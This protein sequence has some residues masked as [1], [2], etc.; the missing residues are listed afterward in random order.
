MPEIIDSP[1]KEI[2][3]DLLALRSAVASEGLQF[4]RGRC[5]AIAKLIE[6]RLHLPR[7]SGLFVDDDGRG[8]PHEWNVHPQTREIADLS[9]SQ[10]GSQWRELEIFPPRDIEETRHLAG[11]TFT[12]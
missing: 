10:F 3:Q 1:L 6:E 4:P 7:Q 8:H 11:V 2:E 9:L 12:V 5:W